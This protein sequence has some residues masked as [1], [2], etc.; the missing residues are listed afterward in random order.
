MKILNLILLLSISSFAEEWGMRN[1]EIT[2]ARELM[3]HSCKDSSILVG[4]IDTGIDIKHNDLKDSIWTNPNPIKMNI[5]GDKDLNGWD[6]A[7]DT[8]LTNDFHGHGTHISGIIS[9]KNGVCPGIKL[10]GA[11]YYKET[12]DSM[13]NMTNSAKSFEYLISKRVRVINYSGGGP[14]FSQTEFNLIEK[15]KELGI[16]IVA[17]AGNNQQNS[18]QFLYFP[19]G[20][21]F[22]NIISVGAIGLDNKMPLFSNFGVNTI[23]ITAPGVS[24]VSTTPGGRY[25]YMSGT[26]QATAFVTGVV[27][28]L[29]TENPKLTYKEVIKFVTEG[30]TKL[31]S[32]KSKTKFGASLNAYGAMKVLK[33]E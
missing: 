19:A 8:N 25:G 16:V 3:T 18:D 11:A 32:L 20:Y 15:A 30:A 6:F 28:L 2:K 24:I 17:A 4:I 23:D 12:D 7:R 29:L 27:A 9:G 22:D 1:I 33:N 31:D 21:Q 5:F 26:S 14:W 13:T 10:I